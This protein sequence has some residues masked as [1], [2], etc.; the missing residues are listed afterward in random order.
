MKLCLILS[1]A[2][3]LCGACNPGLGPVVPKTPEERKM[4]GLLEKFDRWD[5]DGNGELDEKELEV[6][7]KERSSIYT[8]A[9]VIGFYDTN[10]NKT[11]SLREAQA[12]YSR[13]HELSKINQRSYSRYEIHL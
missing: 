9:N 2:V 11:I 8:A 1:A 13:A 12:G 7:L 3:V 6:G 4:I 5:Y 10:G